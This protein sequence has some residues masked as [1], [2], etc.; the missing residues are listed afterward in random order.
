M[1]I[2]NLRVLF[3]WH[4]HPAAIIVRCHARFYV[5]FTTR[6]SQTAQSR[7][8]PRRVS[9]FRDSAVIR[10]LKLNLW[11]HSNKDHNILRNLQ[12]MQRLEDSIQG[13]ANNQLFATQQLDMGA[14]KIDV[15]TQQEAVVQALID[16]ADPVTTATLYKKV[17]T[18]C[19]DVPQNTDGGCGCS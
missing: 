6:L 16:A 1:A 5:Q 12:S 2:V 11:T 9:F 14:Q 15:V 17:F 4:Q 13:T 8:R 10:E 3:S 18:D 19:C 7:L